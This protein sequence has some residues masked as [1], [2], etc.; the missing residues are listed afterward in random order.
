M[1]LLIDAD[2]PLYRAGC[3]NET[4]SY[5]CTHGGH[6]VEE[7]QYKKDAVA[8]AT[9][10]GCDIEKHKEAGAVGLSLHNLRQ[11][12][13]SMLSIEHD[14]YEMYTG[15]KG[16]FRYDYFKEYKGTRDPFDKPIHMKQMKKHLQAKYGAIPV[17]GEEVDDKVSYRQVQCIAEG[18]ESCIVTN[19]KDLDNTMGWHRN[20]V[21]GETYYLTAEQA[22]LNFHR[23]LLTG[24]WSVDGIPG[25]KGVGGVTA[26][27]ILPEYSDNML[28]IVK[29]EYFNRGH[30]IEYLTMNGI[31]LWMRRK[32]DEIWSPNE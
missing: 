10:H 8:Y 20:W 11:C 24:D 15:G 21:K 7:F 16:N 13:K 2:S 3:A 19:D 25:L 5:L 29:E 14:S 26:A 32:P 28:D 27:K 30:D 31:M 23:Q 18:I 22:D 17:D 9:E 4:R 12:V 6:L 1:K